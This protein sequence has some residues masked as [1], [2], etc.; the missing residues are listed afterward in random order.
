MSRHQGKQKAK[1]K[2]KYQ[3]RFANVTAE[4]A[5]GDKVDISLTCSTSNIMWN[6][7][8]L[9]PEQY[10][11]LDILYKQFSEGSISGKI[12][13]HLYSSSNTVQQNEA[14]AL[15]KTHCLDLASLEDV[16]NKWSVK[17]SK[18]MANGERRALYQCDCGRDHTQFGSKVRHT[19]VD[20]TG[21]L[22]HAE[23]SINELTSKVLRVR[24]LLGHN[25]TCQ[26]AILARIPKLPVHPSV[27][28]KALAQ[29]QEGVPLTTI[30]AT[31]RQMF[32]AGTYPGQPKDIRTSKFRWIMK[33]YDT[34]T[35]YRQY[36]QV[37][38]VNTNRAAHLNI[39]T[40]LNPESADY[41]PTLLDAVF[42]YSARAS[43]GERFEVCIATQEMKEAAWKYGHRSQLMLD[44]TFGLCNSRLLLFIIMGVDEKRK[45]IPIAFLM[46][47]APSGNKQTSSGYNTEILTKLLQKWR[48]DVERFGKR[49]F[50]VLV[51][52]TDTDM[53][54]R[55]AL[56]NVFPHIWLLIC[57][58]HIWQSWR[59][60]RNK[61]LRG[62]SP[63]LMNIKARLGRLETELIH[64]TVFV[65]ALQIIDTERQ[66]LTAM[67]QHGE[68]SSAA[69]RGIVH[70]DY[71][72]SFW[73]KEDL[74]RSWSDFG[75]H[76]AAHLLSCQFE[77]VLPTTNH[78]ESFNRLLKRKHLA[79]WQRGGR[80]LRADMLLHL[81]VT[82]VLPSIFDQRRFEA[83]EAMRWENMI[84][85]LPGGEALL[86]AR[87]ES[88]HLARPNIGYLVPDAH[89]DTAAQGL[90]EHNQISVP[91]HCL[92]G[93]LFQCYSAFAT[94][95]DA[96]PQLYQIY[97]G[98]NGVATCSCLD[99][100]SRSGACK[101]IRAAL[102]KTESEAHAL[103]TQLVAT[104]MSESM[105]NLSLC[106]TE[107]SPISKAVATV[108]DIINDIPDDLF[109]DIETV[110]DEEEVESD[111]ESVATD[112]GDE[113][114]FSILCSSSKA[115]LNAQ[116]MA[117]LT[118]ELQSTV[119]KLGDLAAI[120][121]SSGAC[122]Q[123]EHIS[124]LEAFHGTLIHLAEKLQH[125]IID[126]KASQT[127][128]TLS[129]QLTG[130][131]KPSPSAA[132]KRPG[133]PISSARP[134]PIPI[135]PEKAQK[136]K[137]SYSVF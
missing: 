21:C 80:R 11:S 70:L 40:W 134:A 3:I 116:S 12:E 115:A 26:N 23:L 79:R 28:A 101:H 15:L 48:E 105:A 32:R 39:D 29:L 102:L 33:S 77:G 111:S 25:E 74:W 96:Q 31:N 135:S 110:G 117:R 95:Y 18:L 27:Y 118:Y 98:Y 88:G 107:Q 69:E 66:V 104:Q 61:V 16:G 83:Q 76:A 47:S 30:Q 130:A 109:E 22:A 106:A 5:R 43:K 129:A 46:F 19:A 38:G 9:T 50:E 126:A 127:T 10:A 71:L 72:L 120:I 2:P 125:L 91:A 137:Q 45:G 42:H 1:P 60:H 55:G 54:E 81:L 24:G 64:T 113:F 37:I 63:A 89:R 65:F 35:L 108:T 114:D 90:Y 52:I 100:Q 44:G 132:L 41:N 92:D 82:K 51:V 7:L 97:F 87:A 53:K 17:W 131:P 119:P 75:C 36:N 73:M 78:L 58:F 86:K 136:R 133:S 68:N 6:L 84:R 62:N 56:L 67:I 128:I 8:D 103:H 4:E 14:A 57:L 122:V 94:E 99:F 49:S 112:A 85:N 34:R 123:P 93:L 59:N 13:D 121:P 20:F 124:G